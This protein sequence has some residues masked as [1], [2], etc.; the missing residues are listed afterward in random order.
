MLK[1]YKKLKTNKGAAMMVLVIFTLFISLTIIFGIVTPA[2]REFQVANYSFESKQTYFMAESGMEDVFYRIKNN[3]LVDAS[4]VLTNGSTS[5]TTTITNV[6]SNQKEISSLA[7]TNTFQRKVN[8]VLDAGVGTSFFY[9]MQAGIGGIVLSNTAGIIGNVYSNGPINASNSAYVTGSAVSANG[10]SP[11]VDQSN[12]SGVPSSDNIFGNATSTEDI[13][14]SFQLSATNYLS[15]AQLYIKKSGSPSSGV[16]TIR[17][18]SSSRPSG[19]ILATGTLS[20]SLVSPN[21]GWVNVTF[22]SS[23]QLTAGTTYWLTIDSASSSSNYYIIG[24][25]P[26]SYSSGTAKIGRVSSS[27]WAQLGSSTDLFFSVSTGGAFGSISG[28]IVGT[29]GTGDASSHSVTGSTV[30][31]TIYCQTGSG[32]NKS[33]NTSQADPVPQ[34]FPVSDQNIADWKDLALAG[35]TSSGLNLSGSTVQTIGPKKINGNI[36]LSNNAI[37]NT[38]GV[39]WVTGDVSISNSSKFRVDASMGANGGIIIVDGT[40]TTSNSAVFSGSGTTGSYMM[41][42]STNTGNSAIQI[43]NSAGSV[44]LIAPYGGVMLSNTASANQI[45]ANRITL[46]NSATVTYNS[47]LVNAGFSTGPSG[48]WNVASWKEA[49]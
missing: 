40:V 45:T 11:T 18:S 36:T 19:T 10:Q 31:G 13:A 2:V 34:N 27:T 15:S 48:G 41:V 28:L 12:G 43:S 25:S 22:T 49:Q 23:P 7:D 21:Y 29:S 42:I 1:N 24:G 37:L 44:I 17:T 6:G 30:A 20:S 33:C 35:G 46:S 47:G 3:R 4:E 39:L 16:V 32:N 8:M 5:T 14:Q 38:T 9:G 26:A